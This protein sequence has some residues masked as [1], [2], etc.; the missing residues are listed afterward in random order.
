MLSYIMKT[1]DTYL[2]EKLNLNKTK[3]YEYEIVDVKNL[4][5]LKDWVHNEWDQESSFL[6]PTTIS[7]DDLDELCD[8]MYELDNNG[9][10]KGR[11][12]YYFEPYD[13]KFNVLTVELN[14]NN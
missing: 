5:E 4:D 8:Y 3:S 10:E 14:E 2:T 6:I 12:E 9:G 13:D 11:A 7:D 1:I